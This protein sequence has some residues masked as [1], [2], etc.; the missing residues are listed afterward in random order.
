MNISNK[1]ALLAWEDLKKIIAID[2][3]IDNYKRECFNNEFII[4]YLQENNHDCINFLKESENEL[5]IQLIKQ[6]IQHINKKNK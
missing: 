4:E 1:N 2:N 3:I 5:K 6:L